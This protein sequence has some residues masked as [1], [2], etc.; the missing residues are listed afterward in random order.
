MAAVDVLVPTYN[1]SVML[2]RCLESIQAQTYSDIRVIIGDN[3]SDDDTGTVAQ[4]FCSRD[5][6]F[7]YVRNSTNLGMFGNVNALVSR[8]TAPYVHIMHD[9]DWLEPSFYE[10]MI[11]GLEESPEAGWAWPRVI[12]SEGENET[13]IR[14]PDRFSH[15]QVLP[16]EIAFEELLQG[17]FVTF[18]AVVLRT[19]VLR[20][21][22][23]FSGYISADWLMWL[24]IALHHDLKFIDTPLFHYRLHE[25]QA[26]M[27][28]L[29]MGKGVIDMFEFASGLEEFSGRQTEIAVARFEAVCVYMMVMAMKKEPEA[30]RLIRELSSYFLRHVPDHRGAIRRVE[31]IALAYMVVPFWLRLRKGGRLWDWL[32]H[33]FLSWNKR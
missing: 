25:E 8:A 4:D 12:L 27:D 10:R 22:G 18:P 15:D 2:H 14:L 26:S 1:R 32:R 16:G 17:N 9:D 29:R 28:T 5:R 11:A 20:E 7:S 19:S 33:L 23:P 30:P 21:V 6:R 13:A 31:M 3:C 24:R